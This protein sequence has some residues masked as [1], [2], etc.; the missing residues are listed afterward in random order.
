MKW[1]HG[2]HLTKV[3]PLKRT[4]GLAHSHEELMEILAHRFFGQALPNV[5]E[6][7]NN[8]PDPKLP[9][10]R[11]MVNHELIKELLQKISSCS[12]LGLSRHTWTLIKWAVEAHLPR[13]DIATPGLSFFFFCRLSYSS[14][15][16]FPRTSVT[17][18]AC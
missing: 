6:R 17:P 1:C 9:R 14:P 2:H 8:N 12:A 15:C 7:F 13:S 4:E 18:R 5:P 10:A 3:P 16:A 11:H